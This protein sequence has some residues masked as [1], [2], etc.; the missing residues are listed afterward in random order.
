MRWIPDTVTAAARWCGATVI[1]SLAVLV[2]GGWSPSAS[3]ADLKLARF[4]I[5]VTPP[6]GFPMAY[7]PV[8]RVEELG[9][10]CRGIVLLGADDP[11]VLCAVDWIG[12]G[13]AAHD[14][15]REALAT[16]AGTTPAR[17]AVQ[18]L[19]QHDAPRCDFTA[20]QLLRDAGV[21]DCGHLQGGFARGVLQRLQRA[22]KDALPQAVPVTHAAIGEAEVEKVASNRRIQD[23]TGRVVQTRYTTCRDPKL[24]ALP[25]GII[26]PVLTSVSFWN[27]GQPV[28]VMTYYAC[29]PQSYYRT[30]VPSPDFPGLARLIRGQDLPDVLHVHFNGAGGNI[31]A[32]KYNDGAK[33]NRLVLARRM[34]DGM[35]RAFAASQR[36]PLT[37]EDIGWAVAPVALPLADHLQV[38]RLREQLTQWKTKDYWGSPEQ[39]A[40]ALRCEGGHH[41][42]LTC[43]Q[44]GDA[45]ILHMPGELFVEYQLAA[46]KLRPNLH[47]AMAAYGDY[48]PGYIG[49]EKSYGQGGYETSQRASKVAPGVERVLMDGV[50]Q[51]LT[52]LDEPEQAAQNAAPQNA[53]PNEE[54]PNR[55][56][57]SRKAAIDRSRQT[58]SSSDVTSDVSAREVGTGYAAELPRI[59]PRTPQ[60]SQRLLQ[61]AA[62]YQ[63]QLVAAEPLIGS[64]V[65]VEWDA[66]GRMFVCEMRGYSENRDDNISTIGLL[67][68]DDDDGVYD[69]RTTY[70]AGLK[71]PTALFPFDGGLFVGDAPD[72]L[73][74]KDTDGDGVADVRQTVLTGFGTSNVQGLMN[75]MRW[76][77]ENRI[78]LACSSVGG[79]IVQVGSDREPVNI[80]GRDIMFHPLTFAFEPTSGA[81]QHGMCFDDWGRKFVSSN[82]DHLQQV[83]YEDRLVAR[84][85]FVRPPAARVS[86]A[87]DGPQA[88][89][90]RTS[91][92]EP[93]RIVRTRLRVAGKV[94]GPVE[95]GG[96]PAG[97]FT[98]ATGV[99][100]YRGDAWPAEHRGLAV[101]GDVGSNLVH[102]KR[103]VPQGLE[104][105]GERMDEQTELVSSADIWFRPS[106]FANGP[107]G[108]LFVIDTCREVIEHPKS[109][110]P[111]IKEHLDLTAGRDRG[112]IYRLVPDAF[113]RRPTPRLRAASSRDLVGLLSHDNAWHRETAARL[114]FERQDRTVLPDLL[115]TLTAGTSPRGRLHALYVL[116]GL[117]ALSA[118]TLRSALQ[119]SHAQVRRH[120]VRLVERCGLVDSLADALWP[121]AGDD[122]LSVRCQLAY[123]LG[124]A[125][126]A[127][128]EDV[129]VDILRQDVDDRWVQ[130]AVQ[131][132]VPQSAAGLLSRLLAED[133]FHSAAADRF[134]DQL[135]DQIIRQNQ[136]DD[137]RAIVAAVAQLSAADSQRAVR[138]S[139]RQLRQIQT[140]DPATRAALVRPLQQQLARHLPAV[141]GQAEDSGETTSARVSAIGC[142]PFGEWSQVADTLESSLSA[143]QPQ[144][145]Q[146]AALQALGQ[147]SLPEAAS[148]ILSHWNTLSPARRSTAVEI[149][150]ARPNRL[151]L[152]L[153]AVDRG[154][155]SVADLPLSRLQRL[156]RSATDRNGQRAQALLRGMDVSPRARVVQEYANVLQMTGDVQR[157][158]AV[159]RRECSG[160]HR[161]DGVGHELGP[162]LAAMQS[163]G[164]RALLLNVLDPN[165]EVNPQYVNYVA[166]T[167]SGRSVTGMI[168]AEGAN[169][170]TL[171]RAQ[172]ASDTLLRREI[173]ELQSTG[174]SLMPEGLEKTIDR[175]AMADLLAY[176]QQAS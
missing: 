70:A 129:L 151:S 89:V 174:V 142:L 71:W 22:V 130:L 106:Q 167:E 138:L 9:L 155:V 69:R 163:R 67:S 115:A 2:L 105:R 76:D 136:T 104:F 93:W 25:E 59:P 55:K 124:E 165:R 8:R 61:V 47:V 176:L 161:V 48:G 120:A 175:Q 14:A 123:S 27:E 88:T 18:T 52:A 137:H 42:E 45:R 170:L 15:F 72:V 125:T 99:T 21:V 117:D 79:Q 6:V 171:R 159:F 87:A 20:E 82:S 34:A 62:G 147:F 95:G 75:S 68:D 3:A 53:A 81:A 149:L 103:L 51:L 109:L 143:R 133:G 63:M 146:Q 119:D 16:A 169:S 162:S 28:A 26:D 29:H 66:D 13:N 56:A 39:L 44:V 40:F 118:V 112:R 92:V 98:G 135:M 73:Y 50:R 139:G 116:H 12:I 121:L 41:I 113:V 49:T 30:G 80:R 64:P 78:H 11:I 101:I 134:V 97:Y 102:R 114:L 110:P 36:F 77:L 166:V 100:I 65:A 132:A 83:M 57:V 160:C 35:Q 168:V 172:G 37:A 128:R 152:L 23:E 60:Q 31:G 10:R 150:F 90:F 54:A 32:G 141:I 7:D 1:G 19:H 140:T 84:N 173:D 144:D 38:D 94:P 127:D 145:I 24:R 111:G 91:P 156:A 74:L 108:G 85:P 164:A 158:R 43:L 157:G 4:D 58:A 33:E 46:K 86:I 17:V 153:D 122:S 154:D 131:S 5:D 96:R 148:L 107:D 126:H